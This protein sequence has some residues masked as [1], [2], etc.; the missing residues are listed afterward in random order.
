LP[1]SQKQKPTPNGTSKNAKELFES[2]L[3]SVFADKGED[4][5]EKTLG[6][7]CEISSKLIDPKKAEF[8]NL[9]HIG[10]GNIESQKGTLIDLKTAK[11]EKLISG[12]IFI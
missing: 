11:E 6:E 10:A 7:I 12:K 2:Y 1:L 3:Q 4:W 5:E 8:Q 9:I